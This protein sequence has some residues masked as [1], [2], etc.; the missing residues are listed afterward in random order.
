M[1]SNYRG[2]N[3]EVA[4]LE[5]AK[6]LARIHTHT[7]TLAHSHTQTQGFLIPPNHSHKHTHTPI[8]FSHVAGPLKK[9]TVSLSLYDRA[10]GEK[11]RA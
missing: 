4:K 9:A 3:I 8:V 11:D 2:Y 7:L 10:E 5:T 6:S 1:P